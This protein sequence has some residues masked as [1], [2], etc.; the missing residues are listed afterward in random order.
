MRST[1]GFTLIEVLAAMALLGVCASVLLVAVGNAA[2][3]MV[4]VEN[5]DRLVSVARSLIDAQPWDMEKSGPQQGKWLGGIRWQASITSMA[6][7]EGTTRL[8]RLD[9]TV[10]GGER[11]VQFSTLQLLGRP[12]GT[13]R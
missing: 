9:L 8:A 5:S 4:H 13:N 7:G 10:S 2:R 3:A 11:Q 6:H 1:R 12:A